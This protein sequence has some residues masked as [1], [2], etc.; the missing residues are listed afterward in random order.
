MCVIAYYFSIALISH[1]R[2]NKI[3]GTDTLFWFM[4]DG[5]PPHFALAVREYLNANYEGRWIGR[6]GPVP[7]P[8]RSPD[9]NMLDFFL[10]RYLKSLVYAEPVNNLEHLLHR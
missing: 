10:W 9:L 1:L 7:W 6:D 4:Q 5:A 2:V 3:V 8:P